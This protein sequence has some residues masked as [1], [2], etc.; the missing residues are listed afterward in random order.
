MDDKVSV[1]VYFCD[2]NELRKLLAFEHAY[3]SRSVF[4][5]GLSPSL[6]VRRH[7]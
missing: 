1:I 7:L 5:D 2:D 6:V 3:Y 4:H